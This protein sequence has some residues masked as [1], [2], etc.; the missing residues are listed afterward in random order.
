MEL[1]TG[2]TVPAHVFRE[3]DIRGVVDKDLNEDI[4]YKL[5]RAYGTFLYAQ[6]G[7]KPVKGERMSVAAGRDVRLS[8]E[9]FQAALIKGML[10]SGI[11]VINVGQVPTPVLYFSVKFLDT[12]G[13]AEVTAS[14]NPA[15]YNG[16]KLRKRTGQ[17]LNAPLTSADVQ[18]LLHI[19]Q[20]GEFHEG[21]GEYSDHPTEPEYIDY[22]TKTIKVGRPL[23]VVIDPGNGVTGPTA[24]KVYQALGCDV[25][26]IYIEPDGNFPH[27]LPNPL[28]E[29]NVLDLIAEVK[30]TGADVGIGIDGDG[31]RL[32]VIA[33]DGSIVWP[34]MYMILYARKA[35]Q[36]QPG[37]EIIFDVKCSLVLPEDVEKHGGKPVMWRTGYTNI[38]ARRLETRAPFAGEF[39]GHMFF[40]DPII[41]FDDGIYAGARLLEA[42]GDGDAPISER[43]SD[44]PR[45]FNSSEGRIDIDES[46][47]FVIIDRLKTRFEKEYPLITLDGVRIVFPT[48]W[49]LVRASNT[50]P[51]I[52]YRF[53]STLSSEDLERIK[54]IIRDALNEDGVETEF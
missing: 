6:E 52:T 54:G 39:S 24:L 13:G 32:G 33:N 16:L 46:R 49:A 17:G 5:G 19:I 8:S 44:V 18:G 31:D 47:K 12:D 3:Y 15:E 20:H 21:Q 34:D 4:Y 29:E 27:H 9:R 43:F 11:D 38:F 22:I 10:A 28:K 45:Y 40:D 30:R 26:G 50:E 23:R 36:K 42:L 35:L 53:E 1:A 25:S 41:D 37:G 14:H 51:A 48:G 7:V 2:A